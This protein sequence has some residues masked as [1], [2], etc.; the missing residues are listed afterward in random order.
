MRFYTERL[1]FELTEEATWQGER[2]VFLRCNTRAPLARPVPEDAAR[3]LGLSSHTTSMSFGV[4]L[5]N[6]QQ[7]KDAVDFLRDNGVRVETELIPP[8]LYPGIDYAAH[9][10]DPEATASSSTTTWSRSAGTAAPAEVRAAPGRPG[11]WPD[12]L[13]PLSDTFGGEPFLGPWG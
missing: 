7:L 1:G 6:Y 2:C 13:E 12:T 5:A 4:Q 3:E 10:F 11:N 8:E 9:A